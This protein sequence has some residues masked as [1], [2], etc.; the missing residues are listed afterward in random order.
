MHNIKL[1]SSAII[2]SAN[3]LALLLALTP[4]GVQAGDPIDFSRGKAATPKTERGRLAR[5]LKP[6]GPEIT[7]SL[8]GPEM[9]PPSASYSVR[10]A[11]PKEAQ[12][13]K[14]AAMEKKNWMILDQGQLQEAREE[15]DTF[16]LGSSDG[17]EKEKTEADYWWSS[18]R[19][20]DR[21][22]QGSSRPGGSNRLPGQSRGAASRSSRAPATE[23][24]DQR[25][26][27]AD[28]ADARSQIARQ[29]DP[30]TL[31]SKGTTSSAGSSESATTRPTSDL[32][33]KSTGL[34]GA[35]TGESS[36]SGRNEL[37]GIGGALVHGSGLGLESRADSR[38]GA[39]GSLS[40]PF[41][42]GLFNNG[43]RAAGGGFSSGSSFSSGFGDSSGAP[44]GIGGLGGG[45]GLSDP[46]GSRAGNSILGNSPS[47][48][49]QPNNSVG[50]SLRDERP[51]MPGQ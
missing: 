32:F 13:Q 23:D 4:T 21:K 6:E 29:M 44:G 15:E 27:A 24:G 1:T 26:M 7:S 33:S 45:S 43:P 41:S 50:R 3:G 31:F 35:G 18:Q 17:L 37:P 2:W 51:K 25:H 20:E 39:G 8:A 30:K 40:S 5:E 22:S 14:D 46:Y 19:G 34:V 42:P 36:H 16:G 28:T 47:T 38:S 12:R 48:F 10:A 11:S 9:V 49:Q